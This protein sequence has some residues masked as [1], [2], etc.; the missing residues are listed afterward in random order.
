MSIERRRSALDARRWSRAGEEPD[1]A[2]LLADPV[3]HLVMRRDGVSTA[4]LLAVITDA[5]AKMWDRLCPC[6]AA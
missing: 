6:A 3:V 1:L 2:D 5:R 4:E